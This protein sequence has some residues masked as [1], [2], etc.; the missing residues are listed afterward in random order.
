GFIDKF[1]KSADAF[2]AEAT[3]SRD[4]TLFPQKDKKSL[5]VIDGKLDEKFY[6]ALP[7][8]SFVRTDA[9][10]APRYQTTFKVGISGS[11]LVVGVRAADPENRAARVDR[12]AHDG[13]IF[14]DD[15]IE[16]FIVPDISKGDDVKNI[17]VNLAG[18]IADYERLASTGTNSNNHKFESNARVAVKRAED[19][20]VM[21]IAVPLA[22]LG[23]KNNVFRMNV[24]RNKY[25]GVGENHERSVWSCTYGG[26]WSFGQLPYLRIVSD[27]DAAVLVALSSGDDNAALFKA[28]DEVKKLFPIVKKLSIGIDSGDFTV[29][30]KLVKSPLDLMSHRAVK[31]VLNTASTGIMVRLGRVT[32]NWMSFVDVT[33]KKLIDRAIRLISSIGK[34]SYEDSCYKLFDAIE[35]LQNMAD[36]DPEKLP[37]VQY[38]LRRL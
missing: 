38:V 12:S 17:T 13:D 8:H 21:E 34:I 4:Q 23:I 22:K 5:A 10:L 7:E 19:H 36:D 6:A 28:F 24:C 31:L 32:G 27:K 26:F 37:V 1:F 2:A 25:S 14:M 30:C 18:V 29:T 33:N 20:Y 16:L 35:K 3:V 9:P 11:D 15:S